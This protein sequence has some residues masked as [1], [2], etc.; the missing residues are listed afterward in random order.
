MQHQ[1]TKNGLNIIAVNI[2]GIRVVGVYK[3][4]KLPPGITSAASFF[5]NVISCLYNFTQTDRRIIV[6]G[7]FNVDLYRLEKMTKLIISN[8]YQYYHDIYYHYEQ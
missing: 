6:G 4:F 2:S 7:D 5:G 8:W 1:N 3:G